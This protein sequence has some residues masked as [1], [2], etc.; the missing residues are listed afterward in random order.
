MPQTN[1]NFKISNNEQQDNRWNRVC[2]C[3]ALCASGVRRTSHPANVM[4][5]RLTADKSGAYTGTVSLKDSHQG[6]ASAAGNTITTS[7]KL[8]GNIGLAYEAQAM[9]LNEGGSVTATNGT[10]SFK[11]CD[12]L[13]V[14]L[15]C[16]T[17]RRH[18]INT[19]AT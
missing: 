18:C 17:E 7:G 2:G 3:R 10:V 12:S 13:L 11:G 16:G 4:V 5:F 6:E 8:G 19:R 15:D 14:L 1:N 9:V